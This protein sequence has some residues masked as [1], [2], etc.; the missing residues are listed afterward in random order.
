[1]KAITANR[2]GDGVAVYLSA[3]GAWAERLADAALFEDAEAAAAPLAEAEAWED[4]VVGPYVMDID[5]DR[6]AAGQKVIRET[7]RATG[8]SVRPDL[9]K[10]AEGLAPSAQS[11]AF[12]TAAMQAED[13]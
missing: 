9:G 5:A 4:L 11:V 7:I 10:Q 12:Q 1:M 6:L 3:E 2:L 8:P 13:A